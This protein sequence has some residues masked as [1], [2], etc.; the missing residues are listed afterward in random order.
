[1]IH[2]CLANSQKDVK[3]DEAHLFCYSIGVTLGL[4]RPKDI[5]CGQHIESLSQLAS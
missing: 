5:P 4:K 1:M 2:R 3:T